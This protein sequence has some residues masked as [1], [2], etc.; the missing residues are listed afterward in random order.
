MY[1]S[2]ASIFYETLLLFVLIVKIWCDMATY[3]EWTYVFPYMQPFCEES[4]PQ[5]V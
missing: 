3:T 2:G 1:I 4:G 5:L